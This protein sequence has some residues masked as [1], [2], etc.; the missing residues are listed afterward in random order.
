M[1]LELDHVVKLNR[2]DN[3]EAI[4]KYWLREEKTSCVDC[5]MLVQCGACGNLETLLGI[6]NVKVVR[7][8][9]ML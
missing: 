2:V 5:A 7:Y 6:Y 3:F 4:A 8:T 1:W 9:Q